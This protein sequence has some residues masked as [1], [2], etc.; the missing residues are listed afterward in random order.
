MGQK[1]GHVLSLRPGS[2]KPGATLAAVTPADA[3][4]DFAPAAAPL[5]RMCK[6]ILV[7]IRSMQGMVAVRAGWARL[8]PEETRV[9]VP[10]IVALLA[11]VLALGVTSITPVTAAEDN[12][13]DRGSR[14]NGPNGPAFAASSSDD[15]SASSH[16]DNNSEILWAVI[17]GDGSTA[18]DHGALDS[19]RFETGVYGVLFD[20]DV[21]D[22]AYLATLGNTGAGNPDPGEIT[23]ARFPEETQAVSI[24]T[25]NSRVLLG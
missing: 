17:R 15:V 16:N 14:A 1:P 24:F 5:C 18:R 11:V 25:F 4:D 2:T 20:R 21:E 7:H 23:V 19:I 8:V 12:G 13:P 10:R 9:K 3:H 22:C 6:A